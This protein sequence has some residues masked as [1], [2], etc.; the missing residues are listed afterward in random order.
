MPSPP[1]R[2]A[3]LECDTPLPGTK[4]KYGGYGGVF[5]SLFNTAADTLPATQTPTGCLPH[6]TSFSKSDLQLSVYDVVEKQEYPNLDDVDAIMMTGSKY[7]AYHDDPWI[8]KLVEFVKGILDGD[9]RVRIIGVCFGHQIVG[10]A[11][12]AVVK[13]SEEGW[14]ASVIAVDLT[15][16]GQEIFGRPSLVSPMLFSSFLLL[17]IQGHPG[18]IKVDY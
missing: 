14:E 2:I 3:I 4:A 18:P 12:G 5:T 13:L 7:T 16:K 10:R 8:L 15:K 6:P 1:L 17:R 11:A 9:G